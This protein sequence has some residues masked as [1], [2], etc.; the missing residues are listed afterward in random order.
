M[1][2]AIESVTCLTA[3]GDVVTYP[4]SELTFA[5]RAT[6]IPDPVVLS[7]T[8]T[9]TETDPIALRDRVKEIFAFKKSTQPLADH[10]AGCTFRNVLDPVSEKLVPAGKLIDEAGLKGESHGGATVS[11]QHANFIVTEAGAT[12]DDVLQL[13]ERV[14]RRVFEMTGYDLEPEIAIW[15]R[16][17]AGAR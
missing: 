16:D 13:L 6:N 14:R 3:E 5:Y 10:S 8:A 7:V 4:A 15:R 1:G 9:L 11:R 12:A 17:G 2:D